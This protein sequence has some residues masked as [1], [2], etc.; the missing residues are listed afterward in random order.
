MAPEYKLWSFFG[1]QFTY[2]I[3]FFV[4]G[5]S[6]CMYVNKRMKERKKK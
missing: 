6:I 4:L 3:I 1:D 5:L 2:L